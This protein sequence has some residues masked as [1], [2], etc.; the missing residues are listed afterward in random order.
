MNR[1]ERRAQEHGRDQGEARQDNLLTQAENQGAAAGMGG[2]EDT[3][4]DPGTVAK[5]VA[6]DKDMA[7]PGTG[8]AVESDGRLPHHEGMHLPNV[9][10]A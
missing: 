7:N 4:N 9:P 2:A 6:G 1:E 5:G 10:N 8:G 3:A